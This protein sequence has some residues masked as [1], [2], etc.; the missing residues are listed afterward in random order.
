M[1]AT[2]QKIWRDYILY[3]VMMVLSIVNIPAMIYDNFVSRLLTKHSYVFM[4]N[5]HIKEKLTSISS[6]LDIGVGTGYALAAITPEMPRVSVVGI[7]IDKN[8][9]AKATEV[10]QSSPMVEIRYQSFYDLE[11][12]AE[13]YDFIVFSGSFMLMP[14]RE[15]ALAIAKRLL[16]KN[17]Q[18]LF[19]L[20]LYE[21]KP[22]F[23]LLEKIKP[24]L[25]YYT[26]VD[27]GKLVYEDEF[28]NIVK[29]S[30]LNVTKKERIYQNMNPLFF[31]FRFFCIE[32]QVK[33]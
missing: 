3:H 20:T 27:F 29:E 28:M 12:S 17:G 23:K 4:Y 6:M 15:K 5:N 31:I 18:I 9:V 2:V 32:C 21:Q 11:T 1:L 25:K 10:F 26:T 19:L 16:N 8:Y 13:K 30:G 22:R 33:S 24:L 7:D 14:D